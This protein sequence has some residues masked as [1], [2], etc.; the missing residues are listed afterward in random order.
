M[1]ATL[2]K[3]NK[4]SVNIKKTSYI[5]FKPQRKK[6]SSNISLVFENKQ[7]EQKQE[8]KFVGVILTKALLEITHKFY[9]QQI[10][11]IC[12]NNLKATLSFV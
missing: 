10:S 2:I 1:F 3:A 9:L 6:L 12:Q 11:K 4:L 7:L 8:T 5:I